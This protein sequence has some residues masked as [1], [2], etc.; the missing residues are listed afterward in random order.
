MPRSWPLCSSDRCTILLFR[1]LDLPGLAVLHHLLT[2]LPSDYATKVFGFAT[3]GRIYGALVC[4]SGIMSF[5]Q[6]GLDAWTYGPLKGDPLPVNIMMGCVGTILGGALTLY[7]FVQV[8]GHQEKL[9]AA[10]LERMPL[11]CEEEEGY[12]AIKKTSGL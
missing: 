1:K 8:N 3:F 5:A 7:L 12:G 4:I 11:I 2:R 10:D 6:S 9:D